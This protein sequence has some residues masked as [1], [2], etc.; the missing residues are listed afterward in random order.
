VAIAFCPLPGTVK[1]AVRFGLEVV[2]FC[3]LLLWDALPY[4]S[5][6]YAV[7]FGPDSMTALN[8]TDTDPLPSHALTTGEAIANCGQVPAAVHVSI[9]TVTKG[10]G[11]FVSSGGAH[12]WGNDVQ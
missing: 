11:T 5:C 9:C 7:E 1:D 2:T 12:R 8:C 10:N 3:G 6:Q 4:V